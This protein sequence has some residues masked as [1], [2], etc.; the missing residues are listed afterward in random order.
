MVLPSSFQECEEDK[1]EAKR[2]I[3]VTAALIIAFVAAVAV[4]RHIF[5]SSVVANGVC[6]TSACR[7]YAREMLGSSINATV[8]PCDSFS[9]FVCDGW[10][11]RSQL[12]VREYTIQRMLYTFKGLAEE[13]SL[14]TSRPD[15]I[16]RSLLV[17]LSC[18]DLLKADVDALQAVKNALDD[19]GITWPARPMNVD[20]PRTLLHASL[21]LGLDAVVGFVPAQ[22]SGWRIQPGRSFYYVRQRFLVRTNQTDEVYFNVIKDAFANDGAANVS[23]KEVKDLENVAM[24]P[25]NKSV[26]TYDP[27]V[28]SVTQL[29]NESVGDLVDSLTTTLS[30]LGERTE[31]GVDF[32]SN[33]KAYLHAFLTFWRQRGP[34]DVHLFVSWCTVQVAALYA[35]EKLILNYHHG[36]RESAYVR[37]GVFCLTRAFYFARQAL[38]GAYNQR[39]LGPGESAVEAANFTRPVRTALSR[40]LSRFQRS[41]KAVHNWA[42]S[43]GLFRLFQSEDANSSADWSVGK[44]LFIDKWRESSRVVLTRDEEESLHA[45]SA[46]MFWDEAADARDI[47]LMPYSLSFPLFNSS[48][49][50]AV[51]YGG[52]G[53]EVA[54]G[55]ARVLLNAYA[56]NAATQPDVTNMEQCMLESGSAGVEDIR[57]AVADALAASAVFE[58]YRTSSATVDAKKLE[59]FESWSEPQMLFASLC[60]AKCP[61]Q[62]RF[63]FESVCDAPLRHVPEFADAFNCPLPA[64]MNPLRR[65]EQS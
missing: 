20:V 52:L 29:L 4:F 51:N 27:A 30:V 47:R 59:G 14:Q 24:P 44:S 34:E 10:Q 2:P 50:P 13:A 7:E 15:A 22:D 17:F 28:S 1:T 31:D 9:R 25:L 65:C 11:Q 38:F 48:L 46:L 40:R 57:G 6:A 12:S 5:S 61:G 39:V 16:R 36:S 56:E 8:S 19:A 63:L 37:H 21:K 54:S 53:H 58:A 18:H 45:M 49:V 60:F 41:V 26:G 64:P 43:D 33:H 32:V 23:F 55:T 35:N 42:S 62:G 3:I